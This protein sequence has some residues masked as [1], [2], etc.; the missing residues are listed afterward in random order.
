MLGVRIA[1]DE[2][3]ATEVVVGTISTN[4][5]RNGYSA[6]DK[7]HDKAHDIPETSFARFVLCAERLEPDCD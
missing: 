1:S 2:D 5:G 7:A 4:R 3:V 6:H